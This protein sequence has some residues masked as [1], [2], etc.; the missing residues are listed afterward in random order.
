MV[1]EQTAEGVASRSEGITDIKADI[2]ELRRRL[3]VLEQAVVSGLTRP[4]AS[5]RTSQKQRPEM[6]LP[7]QSCADLATRLGVS[8]GTLL[9]T[10]QKGEAYF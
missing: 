3:A 5:S 2:V 1:V 9:K 10:E 8:T 4:F 6:T 7:P